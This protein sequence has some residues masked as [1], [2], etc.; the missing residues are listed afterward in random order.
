MEIIKHGETL[1]AGGIGLLY[2][3]KAPDRSVLLPTEEYRLLHC[4]KRWANTLTDR[5]IDLID[6][7]EDITTSQVICAISDMRGIKKV[8]TE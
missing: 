3:A 5:L 8:C 7:S 2:W 6:K 1:S 4:V